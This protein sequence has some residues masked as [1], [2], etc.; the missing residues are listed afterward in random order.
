MVPATSCTIARRSPVEPVEEGGLADVRSAD[1]RNDGHV[2]VQRN[3]LASAGAA[4]RRGGAA[5]GACA[6][7]GVSVFGRT[8]SACIPAGRFSTFGVTS[9]IARLPIRQIHG[10]AQIASP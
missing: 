7:P 9:K 8:L 3:R 10:D 5:R 2:G 6:T 1:E 4:L